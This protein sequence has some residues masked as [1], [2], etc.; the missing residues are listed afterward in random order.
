MS[1]ITK[2]IQGAKNRAQ[3]SLKFLLFTFLYEDCVVN[4]FALNNRELKSFT[5]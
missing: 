3:N 2:I 5:K 1:E 4:P